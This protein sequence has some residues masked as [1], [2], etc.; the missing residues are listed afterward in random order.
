MCN[1]DEAAKCE[2]IGLGRRSLGRFSPVFFQRARGDI[3]RL[4]TLVSLQAVLK[5]SD[6]RGSGTIACASTGYIVL[7]VWRVD[8]FCG[9]Q[10][11]KSVAA[12]RPRACFQKR[13]T[14]PRRSCCK[15]EGIGDRL[16]SGRRAEV[17]ACADA[18]E[19]RD[20]SLLAAPR[21]T[22]YA[23]AEQPAP[24]GQVCSDQAKH[25]AERDSRR[26]WRWGR[27]GFGRRGGSGLRAVLASS[28]GLLSARGSRSR[29]KLKPPLRSRALQSRRRVRGSARAVR[30]R[31]G[32]LRHRRAAFG[33]GR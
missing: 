17:R 28:L 8:L 19:W 7:C 31:E 13:A 27:L 24:S 20:F 23:T 14:A 5:S 33:R 1:S 3:G 21:S 15:A 30:L 18:A 25:M 10:F 6:L 22:G 2:S 4:A 12:A 9:A 11:G 16:L 26:V 32:T 29:R